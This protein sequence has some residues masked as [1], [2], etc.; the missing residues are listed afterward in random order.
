MSTPVGEVLLSDYSVHE[1]PSEVCESSSA[2]NQDTT[3]YDHG[4]QVIVNKALLARIEVLESEVAVCR[5]KLM[6]QKQKYLR[7]SD[8][9]HNDSLVRFYTGFQTYEVFLS[10]F[11]FLGPSVN[12]LKYWGDKSRGSSKRKTKLVPIDQLFMTLIKLRQN[13]KERDLALRFGIAV[14]TVSKY[15]IT[16]VCF[17][18]CHFSEI[19]W[20]PDVDQVKSTLPV[21]FR[22]SYSNTYTII[23]AT[24]IF[25]E[26]PT[27][28]Q[29]QSSTWSSYKHH[30]TAKVLVACTPNGAVNFVSDLYVGA[31]S[32]VELTRVSGLL[33]KLDGK[34]DIS[35][36][37][38]RGFTIRD[39]LKAINVDLNIPPFME[40]R[41]RLPREGVLQGRKIASLRI[42]I[43]RVIGR[44]K[45][46]SILKHTLPL[47]F[48]RIANQIICVCA[49]LVNFQTVLIPPTC[50]SEDTDSYLL[51][52]FSSDSDYD[53]DTEL[54]DIDV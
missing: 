15:F 40:G 30:N 20:M 14:S 44:I 19:N 8:I 51:S 54:S 37:A 6:N 36:M 46:Y 35:V 9:A 16:W 38:D 39:Q 13:L 18:Y 11:E 47:T 24:E 45:N 4:S 28:L 48:S 1:L 31:I 7:V 53:G 34:Q 52:C 3:S 2:S 25:M 32:D 27:D 12:H 17:L 41:A 26:T 43:E 21:A 33:P 50:D 23:D 22:E 49:W 42:H 29:L 5:S 10:F